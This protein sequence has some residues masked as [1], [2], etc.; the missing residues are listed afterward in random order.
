ME[1]AVAMK[2]TKRQIMQMRQKLQSEID[3]DLLEQLDME[4]EGQ[5]LPMRD[6]PQTTASSQPS[7]APLGQ[8]VDE[9]P[10]PVPAMDRPPKGSPSRK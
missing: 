7:S 4:E 2:T 1:K 3:W 8:L 5:V 9:H 10:G 6:P